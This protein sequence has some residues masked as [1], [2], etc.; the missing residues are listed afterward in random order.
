MRNVVKC[1]FYYCGELLKTCW[2]PFVWLNL[3][4]LLLIA[5]WFIPGFWASIDVWAFRVLNESIRDNFIIQIFWALANVK[6]TDLFGALFIVI[7]TFLY[8]FDGPKESRKSRLAQLIYYLIWFEIGIFSCKQAF[9]ALNVLRDSPTLLCQD[10]VLLSPVAPWLKI[11]DASHWSFPS[12][13]AFI[14]LEWVGFIFAFAGMRLGMVALVTSSIFILPRLISGAHW[15]SDVMLGS[16][17]LALVFVAVACYTP[18]YHYAHTL[19]VGLLPCRKKQKI[20][21]M[22]S[23]ATCPVEH[24]P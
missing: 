20:E 14:I 23:C 7:F 3:T 2:K 13:H 1:M 9:M 16:L 22:T 18:I 12:D 11:K 15:L 24:K 5:S 6:I 8:V 17:P 10:P 4:A 21:N 19:I